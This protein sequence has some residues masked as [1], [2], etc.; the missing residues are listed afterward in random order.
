MLRFCWD[1]YATDGRLDAELVNAIL[2]KSFDKDLE[3][4]ISLLESL[5]RVDDF[6]SS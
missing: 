6:C 3:F 5:G 1:E 2:D 4:G